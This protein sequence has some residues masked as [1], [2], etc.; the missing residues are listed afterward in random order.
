MP[1]M[2]AVADY[3]SALPT[4]PWLT[5]NLKLLNRPTAPVLVTAFK[6]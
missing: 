2:Q 3:M 5:T 4:Q 6:Q 1:T